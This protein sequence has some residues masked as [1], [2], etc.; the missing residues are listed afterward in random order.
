MSKSEYIFHL[1]TNEGTALSFRSPILPH[2]WDELATLPPLA[3]VA[4]IQ[5]GIAYSLLKQDTHTI[6]S[7]TPTDDF[8]LG[9]SRVSS[10]LEPYIARPSRYL[11]MAT[12]L[13]QEQ[14]WQEC[15]GKPKAITNALSTDIERWPIVGAIDEAGLAY[16]QDF[17]GIWPT[18]SLPVEVLAAL[19]NSP[20]INA[21]LTAHSFPE[22]NLRAALQQAPIPR[23]SK[24]DIQLITSLVRN[25]RT[26]RERWLKEQ[27]GLTGQGILGRIESVILGSYHLSLQAEKDLVAYFE[28]YQRPGPIEL[29]QVEPSHQNRL[30]STIVEIEGIR[31]E[32]DDDI[33]DAIVVSW[34][35][36]QTIHLPLSLIPQEIRRKVSPDVR[37]F[38]R[39]NIGAEYERDL[40]FE[41]IQLPPE[42]R[43]PW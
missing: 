24:A 12:R 28:G 13:S 31:H 40:V 14:A 38:A 4:D 8:A 42:P 7:D 15:W 2:L 29:T 6:F 5:L 10:E 18:A 22:H 37:L 20:I 19:I 26:T 30:C 43:H 16:T 32:G 41:D 23:F 1:S 35:P 21:F 11:N 25:Y 36:Y 9:F 34:N 3:D 27:E 33:V 17:Y 39:V